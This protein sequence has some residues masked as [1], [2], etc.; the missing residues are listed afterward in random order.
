[1]DE[2]IK[3][4]DNREFVSSGVKNNAQKD[5]NPLKVNPVTDELICE[6]VAITYNKVPYPRI[7]IDDNREGVALAVDNSGVI[8]PLVVDPTSGALLIEIT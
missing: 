3:Q 5:I 1:M 7:E 6:V 2:E 4:D 8:V